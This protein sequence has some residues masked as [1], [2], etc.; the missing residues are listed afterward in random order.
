LTQASK[1]AL[2]VQNGSPVRE[3]QRLDGPFFDGWQQAF[4]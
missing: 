3:L 2:P 4:T 1:L